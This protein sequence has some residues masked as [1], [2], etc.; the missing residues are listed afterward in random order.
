MRL[1]RKKVFGVG[2]ND[3]ESTV[4]HVTNGKRY[5][6]KHYEIWQDM[7]RRCYSEKCQKRQPTYV[8]CSV[9]PE[10]HIFSNFRS[11]AE[12]KNTKGMQLDKDIIFPGNKVYSPESCVFVTGALNKFLNNSAR[13]RGKFLIGVSL[14]KRSNKFRSHCKDPFK[15]KLEYLGLFESETEAHEA[16]RSRKQ[17]HA[18]SYANMQADRRVSEALKKMFLPKELMQ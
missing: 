18:I 5:I 13:K 2:I 11:W 15:S 9:D 3:S 17:Q 1:K 7:L 4:S 6:C 14:C 16:W 12:T 10:W 8:G